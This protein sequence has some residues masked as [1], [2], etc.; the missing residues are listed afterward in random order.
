[1]RGGDILTVDARPEASGF[2]CVTLTGPATEV[3]SGEI[4]L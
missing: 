4:R 3:F 1:V 2:S